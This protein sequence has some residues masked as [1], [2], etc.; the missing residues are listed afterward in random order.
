MSVHTLPAEQA[1]QRLGATCDPLGGFSTIIDA[2]SEDE[3]AHDH[4]PHAV[5]WPSLNNAERVLVGTLYKQVGAFDAQKRGAALV[6]A[7]I[8]RHIA[9]HVL[10]LPKSW[11]PLIYCWRGGKR[12]GSL[13]LVL[14]QIG[15]KV[16]LIE[17]G[18]K[19]FRTALLADLPRQVARLQFRV[20]CGPTG[21][22]KTRLLQS[23]SDAGA[24]VLDL[25]SL[26]SHRS[27]VLGVLPGRPQPS[28]KHFDTLIWTA[29][30]GFDAL[31]PVFV[32]SE[33]RK[34]GNLSVP[35]SLMM[36]M[37]A[38][39][40]I[41]LQLSDDERV[42]LLMEDYDFFVQD[43]GFFCQRLDALTELRG[44]HTVEDWK[45]RV[46]NGDLESVVQ[47]LLHSHYDPTYNVSLKRNFAQAEQAPLVVLQDRSA[48]SLRNAAQRLLH[49]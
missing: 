23:L 5:N 30:R 42:A 33:S 17:G 7:N 34:V 43:R 31:R 48:D 10:D 4:L 49:S 3:F 47:E 13:A 6:S 1:I 9:Q 39:P 32:E 14:G 22:G 38:S 35:E 16:T 20:I 27:S 18:Y 2:R 41:Q 44:K 26:A 36:A 21:S 29:L 46:M 45:S 40:C 28:Q 24:Q 19:A 8:S 25:E 12:S 11:Q 15:F 37:R